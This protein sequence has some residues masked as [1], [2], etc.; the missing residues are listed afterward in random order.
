MKREEVKSQIPGITDAQLDWVM[1]Q[2]GNGI[3]REKATAETLRGQ[4]E[5]AQQQLQTAQEQLKSFEG[6]DVAQL[7]GKVKELEDSLSAQAAAFAF[8]T[9][10]DG[11]IRSARGHN[12]KAI[13][14]LL[15]VD[16]LKASQNRTADIQEALAQLAKS[17]P[18]AFAVEDG[19]K[20][21]GSYVNTGSQHGEGGNGAEPDGVLARFQA[22]NPGMKI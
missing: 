9:E 10:L 18:W 3:T 7:K 15:D 20:G 8:D 19:G 12:V 5:T 22:L 2:Y 1:N 11:A 16:K 21:S 6:V 13:R 17:E 14:S 4:L